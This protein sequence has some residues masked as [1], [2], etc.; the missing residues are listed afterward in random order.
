MLPTTL[1]LQGSYT[2]GKSIDTGSATIA[3]DQFSN[4]IN[5]LPWFDMRL[6]RAP[7]DFNIG[8]SL[9]VHFT[10]PVPAPNSKMLRTVG[11]GWQF[12]GTFQASSGAPFTVLLG[13]DPLGLHS[14]DPTDV[15]DRVYGAACT[16]PFHDPRAFSYV[17]LNCFRFPVPSNRRGNLR[18]NS[19][20]GPGLRTLD[21]F[22]TKDNFVKRTAD[23][24][25]VQFRVEAFNV[26]N[27][28]NF[29]PPLDHKVLFN[30]DGTPVPGGGLIDSTQTPPRQ[31]QLGLKLIW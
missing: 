11:S 7:S 5:S 13:G 25:N 4:S 24:F 9:S 31:V 22:L 3:G 8:Q 21:V 1:Q 19:L 30:Q 10:W 17:N 2:W 14:T 26:F 27:R 23:R 28:A 12:G 16:K 20:I 18:R 15:P 6:N 29:A